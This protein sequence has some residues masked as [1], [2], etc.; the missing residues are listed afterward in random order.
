VVAVSFIDWAI[1]DSSVEI[2]WLELF[3]TLVKLT[4]SASWWPSSSKGVLRVRR[5]SRT[6]VPLLS[7]SKKLVGTSRSWWKFPFSS[8][9]PSRAWTKK[10]K[11]LVPESSLSNSFPNSSSSNVKVRKYCYGLINILSLT[12]R[13]MVL[14]LF[15]ASLMVVRE[16]MPFQLTPLC[17]FLFL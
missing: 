14:D 12:L 1:G 10:W 16:F 13:K 3:S 7:S 8:L 5:V 17:A 4:G 9:K 2:F 15:K 6:L 11:S